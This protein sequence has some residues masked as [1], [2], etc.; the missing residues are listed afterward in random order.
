V[1]AGWY[2]QVN[3]KSLNSQDIHRN[4]NLTASDFA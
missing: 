3:L 4:K 1:D 2:P